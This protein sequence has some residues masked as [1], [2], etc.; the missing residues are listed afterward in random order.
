[1]RA[2]HQQHPPRE[3]VLRADRRLSYGEVKRVLRT[4]QAADFAAG[5]PR[6]RNALGPSAE[7]GER[8]AERGLSLVGRSRQHS[9]RLA[10]MP[11][12]A[13]RGARGTPSSRSDASPAARSRARR[14]ARGPDARPRD[15]RESPRAGARAPRAARR[16][17]SPSAGASARSRAAASVAGGAPDRER[18][19]RGSTTWSDP[20]GTSGCRCGS[21][22]GSL[23]WKLWYPSPLVTSASRRCRAPSSPRCR[24]ASP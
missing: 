16:G 23:W 3:I 18:S 20:T 11:A 22:S 12:R 1:M 17:P 5:R 7:E 14:R 13:A 10:P 4:V 15:G 8:L 2:L 9:Q 19:G 6:R 24:A 21:R